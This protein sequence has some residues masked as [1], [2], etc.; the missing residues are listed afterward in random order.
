MVPAR[1]RSEERPFCQYLPQSRISEESRLCRLC[2]SQ[3]PIPLQ[4]RTVEEAA[5][6]GQPSR[7]HAR[8]DFPRR[9]TLEN[10]QLPPASPHIIS[11]QAFEISR[12]R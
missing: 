10:R 8:F 11:R 2:V 6:P 12:M 4:E 1:K 9:F 3:R 7:T 5:M